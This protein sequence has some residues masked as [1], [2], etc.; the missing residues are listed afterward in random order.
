MTSTDQPSFCS[1]IRTL[2]SLSLFSPLPQVS[3]STHFMNDLGLD[4]L[5][6]VE[7]VMAVETEFDLEISDADAEKIVYGSYLW[8]AV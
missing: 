4:S 8:C 5:D 3:G 1:P 2:L 6:A 7:L